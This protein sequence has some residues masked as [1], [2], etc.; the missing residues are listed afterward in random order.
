MVCEIG[1]NIIGVRGEVWWNFVFHGGKA[2]RV[3][4]VMYC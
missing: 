2:R 1:E 3:E 4:V